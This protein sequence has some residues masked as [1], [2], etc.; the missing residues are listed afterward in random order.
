M[1]ADP[2]RCRRGAREL[3]DKL[4]RATAARRPGC[5]RG[6]ALVTDAAQAEAERLKD[7]YVSTEHLFLAIAAERRPLARRRSCCRQRGITR[8]A[9]LQA[10]TA[11]AASSASRARTR[12]AT[13]QALER[14][15]AT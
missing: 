7:E 6:F 9:I 3:L 13:Y 11:S 8:D 4:P 10:L 5:R 15:A 14:T 2:R 1:N 12:R